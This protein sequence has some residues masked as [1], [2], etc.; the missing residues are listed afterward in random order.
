MTEHTCYLGCEVCMGN[1]EKA[2]RP[3]SGPLEVCEAY[4]AGEHAVDADCLACRPDGV[5][6]PEPTDTSEE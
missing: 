3:M 1:L 6:L 4:Q 5:V 2:K